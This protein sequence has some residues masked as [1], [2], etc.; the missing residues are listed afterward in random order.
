MPLHL[1]LPAFLG[2]LG[3]T[4]VIVIVIMI[5]VLFGARKIPQ[6]ARGLGQGMREFKDA[7]KGVRDEVE[8]EERELNEASQTFANEVEDEDEA[9]RKRSAQATKRKK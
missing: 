8:R 2:P 5:L 1:F 7:A 4:E 6:F 9:P 3:T